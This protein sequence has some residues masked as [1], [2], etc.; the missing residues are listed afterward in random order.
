MNEETIY[1]NTEYRKQIKAL[2]KFNIFVKDRITKKNEIK[3]ARLKKEKKLLAPLFYK[4]LFNFYNLIKII[5]NKWIYKSTYDLKLSLEFFFLEKTLKKKK[6]KIIFKNQLILE[7]FFNG[8]IYF[9][10]I[11]NWLWTDE[12]NKWASFTDLIEYNFFNIGIII[13]YINNYFFEFIPFLMKSYNIILFNFFFDLEYS[14][15]IINLYNIFSLNEL[16]IFFILY[17]VKEI[18]LEHDKNI[19]PEKKWKNIRTVLFDYLELDILN[20]YFFLSFF[21]FSIYEFYIMPNIYQIHYITVTFF[22]YWTNLIIEKNVD[23]YVFLKSQKKEEIFKFNTYNLKNLY[24]KIYKKKFFAIRVKYNLF[25]SNIDYFLF[26]KGYTFNIYIRNYEYFF[27]FVSHKK[28]F[29]KY[30]NPA[31]INKTLLTMWNY[32]K[33]YKKILFL[34]KNDMN[35]KLDLFDIKRFEP[36]FNYY[37][38]RNNFDS[39]Y[40]IDL[41]FK[42]FNVRFLYK[43]KYSDPFFFSINKFFF[44]NLMDFSNMKNILESYKNVMATE[45]VYEYRFANSAF[46][47]MEEFILTIFKSP[48]ENVIF[49]NEFYKESSYNIIHNIYKNIEKKYFFKDFFN[50]NKKKYWKHYFLFFKYFNRI[51]KIRIYFFKFN[52]LWDLIENEK[53]ENLF[54]IN[55]FSKFYDIFENKKIFKLLHK[56]KRKH[57]YKRWSIKNFFNILK[58][59]SMFYLDIYNMYILFS[60]WL[61][62]IAFFFRLMILVK[63]YNKFLH[64][65]KLYNYYKYMISLK[66]FF[67]QLMHE[68]VEYL[69]VYLYLYSLKIKNSNNFYFLNI[70]NKINNNFIYRK[71]MLNSWLEFD[72][73]NDLFDDLDRFEKENYSLKLSKWILRYFYEKSELH[74]F[75]S[76]ALNNNYEN[77]KRLFI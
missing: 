15:N 47:T 25:L 56:F 34:M 5:F 29:L 42:D 30:N 12:W 31:S 62:E 70:K 48:L 73:F 67:F 33:L 37:Y 40:M 22:E 71:Y 20:N 69:L 9:F 3:E 46:K 1:Y 76:E 17:N 6:L 65:F 2:S 61:Y 52:Y 32:D 64:F 51:F 59:N 24:I 55:V 23:K 49:F 7:Y 77:K 38:R 21:S 14:D 4:I 10:L 13:K 44:F 28:Y 68:N 54:K 75:Y 63:I 58:Y 53:G 18:K 11:I 57:F 74:M 45:S 50:F 66:D 43:L 72:Y 26:I 60:G 27:E 19:T 39:S 36:F 16:N 41:F 35:R 8:F